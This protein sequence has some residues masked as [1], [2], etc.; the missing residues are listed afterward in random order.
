MIEV[1]ND[2]EWELYDP[3]KVAT[4]VGGAVSFLASLWLV[5]IL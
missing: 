3:L 5:V 2:I 4:V 1:N